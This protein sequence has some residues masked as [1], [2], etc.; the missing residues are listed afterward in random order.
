[1]QMTI[2]AKIKINPT[3]E[4]IE[5]LKSTLDAY[6]TGCNY[7]SSLVFE[8]KQLAQAK[9][10]K[11]TYGTLRSVYF[12]RSQMAQSV[13]K[14]VIARYQSLKSNGHDWTKVMFKKPEY[15]LVWNR[16]YS[17][18]QG[19]FSINTLRGRVKVPFE[20]KGMEQYFDGT[21][22]FGTAKL[23]NKYRKFFLH[24]PM[25]KKIPEASEYTINQV[26]GIDMGMNFVAVS[27]DSQGKSLFFNG[28]SIKDKRS[29]YKHMRKQLQQVGTAS[30]RRK[31]KRIGERENRWM[32]DINHQVSKALVERYG[33]N[34]LFVV[35]DLMGVRQAIERVKIKDRYETVS[36]AF[37]QLRQMI[38][39]KALMAGSKVIAVSPRYTS[40]TCPKCGHTEK[41]NRNRKNH[42]FCCKTCEYKSNDDRIGAM[43][44]QR[45]GIEYIAEV[46]TQV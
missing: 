15:D 6:R 46:T 30:A 14:T 5:W 12:L 41:A 31:L 28:R 18:T 13:M 23:V 43:N 17:L 36:W 20:T 29:N 38:E 32:S 16:D 34:T 22:S 2:T 45:K 42:T 24:I 37:Y 25:T 27:Y 21:W 9:V 19:L 26:V 3:S 35:E 39:Y 33:A 40:Q 4:Q 7:V 44:L 8:T 10:H 1:M 11:M